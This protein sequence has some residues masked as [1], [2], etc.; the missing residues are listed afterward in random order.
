MERST[1]VGA[2][3]AAGAGS[4]RDAL[5]SAVTAEGPFALI[6]DTA[7]G[8]PMRVYAQAPRSLRAVLLAARAFGDRP[9]LLYEDERLSF[10]EHHAQLAALARHLADAGVIK[11]ERWRW[12]CATIPTGGSAF[13]PVRPSAR[14]WWR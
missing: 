3:P 9:F 13:G 6:D 11:G 7:S 2:A 8:H 5:I 1:A 4:T 14:W 12:A 10:A